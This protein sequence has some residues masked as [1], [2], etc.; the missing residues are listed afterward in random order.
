MAASKAFNISAC[1]PQELRACFALMSAAFGRNA[2]VINVL[3]PNHFTPTG[4]EQGTKRLEQW[5]QSE[6]HAHFIKATSSLPNVHKPGVSGFAVWTLMPEQP[7]QELDDTE[8][9]GA[10]W[11]RLE[12]AEV[13]TEFAR[14]IWRRYVKPRSAAVRESNGKGVYGRSRC[15]VRR[16]VGSWRCSLGV[17]NRPSRGARPGVRRGSRP[18]GNEGGR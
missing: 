14:Q 12:N 6:P 15:K 9:A 13:E 7:P 10:V 18:V 4:A 8:D 3:F 11:G 1:A 17:A 2:P 16:L 5:Q